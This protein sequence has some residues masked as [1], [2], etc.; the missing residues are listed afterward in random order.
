MSFITAQQTKLDLELIP[1]ENIIDIVKCNGIIPHGLK[2]R[3][4]TFQGVLDA[5]DLIPC[6]SSFPITVDVPKVYMHQFWN[7][8]LE[9]KESKAYKTYLGYASGVVPPN[10]DRKFKKASPS[11]KDSS[12]VLVDDEP[13][14]KGKRV[15]R[16]AKKSTTT[17]N[18]C[19]I[20]N[21][22]PV[23]TQSKR[24]EK[25][26]VAHGKGIELLSE[27]ALA[28]KAQMKEVRKKEFDGISW[29]HP[30]GSG[31]IV[32]TPP[33]VEKTKSSVTSVGTSDKLGVPNVTKDDSTES[34]LES[35]GNDEDNIN[36]ENEGN[37]EENKSGDDKTPSNS[38][39]GLNSEQD[40]DR[41]DEFANT[42][43]NTDDEEDA[44]LKSKNDDKSEGD[45]DRGMDD[46]T[47]QFNDDV[48]DKEAD[49]EMTDAQ[50]EKE[51]LEIT[52]EQVVED[53]HVTILTVAKET[54]VPDASFSHSS[55]L[56]S[57][58]KF[59]RYSS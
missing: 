46:T 2:P 29:T 54:K 43:P 24:K 18:T 39:K 15:K 6:Y 58:Y 31:M 25:V 13:P 16:S 41:K 44:N 51:N 26:D 8:V 56:A 4:P 45:K 48:Q 12:L 7:F 21:E 3:E 49:V 14:K 59:F 17:L 55:D 28:E 37:D 52:Q 36:D 22:D 11:K 9:M 34:E 47:N 33:S 30:S 40:T 57:N 10:T 38:E 32:E 50:Q 20:I 53:A 23:D 1:K 27:V 35:W 42:L 5:L 19:I